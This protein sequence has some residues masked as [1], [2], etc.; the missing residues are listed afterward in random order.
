MSK[1][2]L[3]THSWTKSDHDIEGVKHASCSSWD[4]IFI[5]CAADEVDCDKQSLVLLYVWQLLGLT[6][7]PLHCSV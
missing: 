1:V 6:G 4:I 2:Y 7:R 3:T 5:E